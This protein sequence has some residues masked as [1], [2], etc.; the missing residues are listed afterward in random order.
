MV[1]KPMVTIRP[2]FSGEIL[3]FGP[4]SWCPKKSLRNPDLELKIFY[5][6]KA[7]IVLNLCKHSSHGPWSAEVYSSYVSTWKKVLPQN[8]GEVFP[9]F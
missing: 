7:R 2:G 3:H 9:S 6:F 1:Y 8:F 4:R 5:H